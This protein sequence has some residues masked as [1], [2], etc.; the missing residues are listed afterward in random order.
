MSPGAST[1]RAEPACA[2]DVALDGLVGPRDQQERGDPP[3]RRPTVASRCTSAIELPVDLGEPPEA[4]AAIRTARARRLSMRARRERRRRCHPE[5]PRQR[6]RAITF[7]PSPHAQRSVVA[8]GARGVRHRVRPRGDSRRTR[9]ARRGPRAGASAIRSIF[10]SRAPMCR[11]STSRDSRRLEL[12]SPGEVREGFRSIAREV[13]RARGE[14]AHAR[15]H[16]QPARRRVRRVCASRSSVAR[17]D[18]LRIE[19]DDPHRPKLDAPAD[20]ARAGRSRASLAACSRA[21]TAARSFRS[22][23][24]RSGRALLE[25][26]R[27]VLAASRWCSPT[28]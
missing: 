24:R 8:P 16:G 14:R 18:R 12:R 4:A 20:H 13:R 9:R 23:T 21:S 19:L 28:R 27:A 10:A 2:R 1:S 6:A 5:A 26:A 25:R 11:R 7:G 17:P 22:S 15:R 3:R